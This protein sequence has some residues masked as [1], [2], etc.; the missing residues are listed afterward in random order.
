MSVSWDPD[1]AESKVF[2]VG[3]QVPRPTVPK[4][5]TIQPTSREELVIRAVL[6]QP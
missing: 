3:V 1:G 6:P 5:K 4:L 2:E